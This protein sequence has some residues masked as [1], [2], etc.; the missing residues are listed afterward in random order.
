M[1]ILSGGWKDEF[2]SSLLTLNTTDLPRDTLLP[3]CADVL[4]SPCFAC[5][6]VRYQIAI[7]LLSLITLQPSGCKQQLGNLSCAPGKH[8]SKTTAPPMGSAPRG[9]VLQGSLFGG[10]GPS[11]AGV[12]GWGALPGEEPRPHG[13]GRQGI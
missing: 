10:G 6:S 8:A 5:C 13:V 3:F 12:P 2:E 9:T 4:P 11:A 7:D 1:F